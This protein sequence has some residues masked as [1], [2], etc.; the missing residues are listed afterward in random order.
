MWENI[1]DTAQNLLLSKLNHRYLIQVQQHYHVLELVPG[2]VNHVALPTLPALVEYLSAGLDSYSPLHLDSMALEEHDLALL[3]P[4][5]LPNC[6][7]VF[8][9]INEEHADLYVLDEFNALW[10]QRFALA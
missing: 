8:Y 3:L 4:Q 6:I 5:G 9:R 2:Q 10:Q 1:F 7:Q